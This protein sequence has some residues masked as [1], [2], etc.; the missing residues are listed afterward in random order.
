MANQS[1]PRRV[2]KHLSNGLRALEDKFDAVTQDASMRL[3]LE[4]IASKSYIPLFLLGVDL[5]EWSQFSDRY[6]VRQLGTGKCYFDILDIPVSRNAPPSASEKAVA[7]VVQLRELAQPEGAPR[8]LPQQSRSNIRIC[9]DDFCEPNF[10]SEASRKALVSQWRDA[11]PQH[12]FELE[13]CEFF[14]QEF[15]NWDGRTQLKSNSWA[16]VRM[17]IRFE[18][19]FTTGLR[20]GMSC[21]A[22]LNLS[23][24]C[25]SKE[26]TCVLTW[27]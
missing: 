21:F 2:Q 1:F 13:A 24:T 7:T 22:V 12:G 20:K 9:V 14:D 15:R 4:S 23:A 5:D 17:T 3:K 18:E 10:E 11:D 8:N 16:R 26:T 6:H 19:N 27:A 25:S